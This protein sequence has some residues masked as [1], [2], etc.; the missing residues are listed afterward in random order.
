MSAR[1]ELILAASREGTFLER[2]PEAAR[3]ALLADAEV[4]DTRR[5]QTV[6]SAGEAADRIGIVAAG[7]VRTYLTAAD[8]RRLTVRYAKAGAM[9]GSITASRTALGVQAMSDSAIIELRTS[10]LQQC[11]L[12]DGL[13]GL[14]LIA[15]VGLRLR[16]T[17]STL[18][19][20][21]FGSMRERVARHVLDL[22]VE[23]H[24]GRGTSAV[25]TQQGLADAV[26]TV[27]E[28]VARILRDFRVEGLVATVP[29]RIK[30]LDA[31]RLA[32]IIGRDDVSDDYRQ[33]VPERP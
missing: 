26:G 21:T 6:F 17:Y 19:S 15:E 12:N 13:V 24:E 4:I 8:G 18:A 28:V 32:A 33:D 11:M 16:D 9:V 27:R 2:L 3:N 1:D 23:D 29:G 14:L 25:V 22:S 31:D 30:I 5:G 20:N 7:M 10:T